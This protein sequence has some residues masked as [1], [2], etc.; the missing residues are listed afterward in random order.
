MNIVLAIV[1]AYL[2]G[3]IP[4]AYLA[5]KLS[6]GIDLRRH[7]SGNL[8]ATNAYRVLGSQLAALVWVADTAKGAAAVLFL[9]G[10][11]SLPAD[12]VWPIVLGFVAIV[13]HS[14]PLFLG[15]GGGKGVATAAGVF[16]ALSWL[17]ALVSMV[18]WG[19]VLWRTG[20]V[21][22]ASLVAAVTLCVALIAIHGIT[23]PLVVAA[24]L[25]TVFVFWS[26]RENIRRLRS[27]EESRFRG[28]GSSGGAQP[29]GDRGRAGGRV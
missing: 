5:G 3:S 23:S 26:H 19:L 8:G 22:L 16:L 12:S 28:G 6:R 11:F 14:L 10:L 18:A 4:S 7:G 2:L 27:G 17:P 29:E 25:F 24:T 13:G 15:R 21:S 20:Y 1:I 9:P